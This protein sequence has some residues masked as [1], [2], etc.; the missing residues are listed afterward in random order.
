[1]ATYKVGHTGARE[2][3]SPPF[4]SQRSINAFFLAHTVR[5][6]GA[7]A[8]VFC[9]SPLFLPHYTHP[10]LH[11]RTCVRASA[12]EFAYIC[13][14]IYY[15]SNSFSE[16]K[17]SLPGMKNKWAPKLILKLG[18]VFFEFKLKKRDFN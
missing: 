7:A 5:L 15:M 16:G 8:V 12:L 3:T 6:D 11:T 18:Y 1:M 17:P 2:N 14:Y 9:Q 10:H 4:P 13:M